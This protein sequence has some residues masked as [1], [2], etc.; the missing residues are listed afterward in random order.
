MI[1]WCRFCELS[2]LVSLWSTYS[3]EHWQLKAKHKCWWKQQVLSKVLEIEVLPD[4]RMCDHPSLN[5]WARSRLQCTSL[6]F[7]IAVR[8]QWMWKRNNNLEDMMK[9][10]KSVKVLWNWYFGETPKHSGALGSIQ[11][12]WKSGDKAL[13]F[14]PLKIQTCSHYCRYNPYKITFTYWKFSLLLVVVLII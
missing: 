2:C 8:H 10:K 6:F 5:C 12:H 3:A 11:E 1:T 7:S 9:K 13:C 14:I 4:S